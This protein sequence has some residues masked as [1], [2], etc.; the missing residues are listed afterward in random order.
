M[1]RLRLKFAASALMTMALFACSD[2]GNKDFEPE[3]T[4]QNTSSGTSETSSSSSLAEA[5]VS[6]AEVPLVSSS[7]EELYSSSSDPHGTLTDTRDGI[8]KSYKTIF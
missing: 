8:I 4:A 1:K 7:L 5:A 2:L 3:T 6:S